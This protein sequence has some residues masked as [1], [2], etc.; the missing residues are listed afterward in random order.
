[1]IKYVLILLILLIIIDLL[2]SI[3]SNYRRSYYYNKCLNLSKETG[4]KLLVIG[5]PSSGFWNKNIK[6]AYG[7][8]DICLDLLG[9][10][11]PIQ[12]KGDLLNELRK[13]NTNSYVIYESCVLEYID[14]QYI[15]EIKREIKRVSGGHYYG[16]RI[17]PNIFPVNL[18]FI[19]TGTIQKFNSPSLDN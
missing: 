5:D 2:F 12:L 4:K 10:N 18:G 3:F 6:Q 13:M 16:V 14:D 8:G 7:C 15:S 11:C 9:C 19:E 1:M 17:F